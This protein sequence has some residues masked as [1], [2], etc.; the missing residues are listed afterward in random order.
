[1]LSIHAGIS[2][3][4]DALDNNSWKAPR[5][6]TFPQRSPRRSTWTL[7][8][9]QAGWVAC[10]PV[11]CCSHCYDLRQL[12]R[13]VWMIYLC[14]VLLS[15]PQHRLLSEHAAL[16]GAFEW[17]VTLCTLHEVQQN[18]VTLSQ[19]MCGNFLP[20][21]EDST[22]HS[23]VLFCF[24]VPFRDRCEAYLVFSHLLLVKQYPAL[25]VTEQVR[26]Q[27][28]LYLPGRLCTLGSFPT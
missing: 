3:H 6:V 23:R 18:A 15:R 25:T 1:M 16:Q 2:H 27:A 22:S 8:G 4:S 21:P 20:P 24:A 11:P 7:G 9:N 14:P 13:S 17:G 28:F 5:T 19:D 26:L 12:W 10:R